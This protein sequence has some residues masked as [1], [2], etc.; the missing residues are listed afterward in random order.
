M[1]RNAKI[2]SKQYYK[3]YIEMVIVLPK[4]IKTYDILINLMNQINQAKDN[5][6]VVLNFNSLQWIDANLL[7]VFGA[8]LDN[9]MNRIKIQYIKGSISEGIRTL[10][11]KNGFGKYFYFDNLED[12]NGT[13]INYKITN[14]VD[15]KSFA[16]YFKKEVM[17]SNH[18]PSL[19]EELQDKLL[20]NVLEI[21]GNAPMHSGCKKVFSC[22]QIFKHENQLKFTIANTGHTIKENV[23]EYYARQ[24]KMQNYPQKTIEWA[25]K[26]N[27][28]TKIIVNGRSGGL[29]LYYLKEFINKNN[30]TICICSSDELWEL[31]EGIETTKQLNDIFSGTIVTITIRT[32]DQNR[33]YL[34]NDSEQIFCEF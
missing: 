28:S 7:A 30:G 25:T 4:E 9:N 29:G 17:Q 5:D 8:V 10:L 31:S 34:N 20:E 26:E 21:F 12:N 33:Y 19:S 15:I 16:K 18:M 3:G 23:I 32:D 11:A 2:L 14:G 24:L 22:G 1:C 6:T 27:N 13:I